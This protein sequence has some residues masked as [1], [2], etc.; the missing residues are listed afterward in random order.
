MTVA[1]PIRIYYDA[2]CPLCA[3]EMHALAAHDAS[4]RLQLVDCSAPDFHDPY[5]AEAGI[6]PKQAMDFIH[7]CDSDGRWLKGIAVFEAAY[8]AIGVRAM[9]R[10]LAQPRLRPAWDWLYPHVANN[11]I[12]LSRMGLNRLFGK[13]VSMAARRAAARAMACDEDGC[14]TTEASRPHA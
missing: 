3:Q 10:L 6:S 14:D 8:A 7:A 9:A 13:L 4:A 12:W 11:R 2:A 5:L 1:W